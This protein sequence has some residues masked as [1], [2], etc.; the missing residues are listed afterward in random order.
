VD[1]SLNHDYSLPNKF[2]SYLN[3]GVPV[4][5]NQCHAMEAF[6]KKHHCGYVIEKRHAAAE[7][8]AEALLKLGNNTSKLRSMSQNARKVME[9][10]YSWERMEERLYRVYEELL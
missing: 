9:D 7:D 10:I 8:Y 3:N 4:V 1:Q 6:I 2:F 5:V